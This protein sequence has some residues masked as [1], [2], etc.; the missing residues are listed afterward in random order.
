MKKLIGF[1]LILVMMSCKDEPSLQQYFVKVAI[2]K[3]LC[4]WIFHPLF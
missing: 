2:K 4:R 3:N 1:A